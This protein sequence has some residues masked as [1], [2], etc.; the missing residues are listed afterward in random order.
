MP[1]LHAIEIIGH[2]IASLARAVFSLIPFFQQLG[3]FK[4]AAIA[5]IFGVPAILL[6]IYV[7]FKLIR[8]FIKLF[9]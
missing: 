4:D 1:L 8:K 6:T 3:D 2:T 9:R 7:D 5:T